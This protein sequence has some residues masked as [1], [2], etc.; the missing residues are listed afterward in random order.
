MIV[1]NYPKIK[2]SFIQQPKFNLPN[3]PSCKRNDWLEFDKSYYCKNCEY[4]INKQKHQI[5]KKVLWQE[6]DF[7]TR[8]NYAN[9]KIREIWMDFVNFKYSSLEDMI[10][11]LQ[12]LNGKTKLKFYKKK[13]VIVM[14]LWILE[15]IKILLLKMLKVL[16]KLT[17]KCY[18]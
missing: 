18:N 8:L 13:Y 12:E 14:I 11:K 3:C 1:K 16:V 5:D 15:W 7:S 17:M 2:Q 4:K 10:N 9:K 6:R